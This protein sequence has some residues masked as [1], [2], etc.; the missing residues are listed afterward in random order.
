MVRPTVSDLNPVELKYYPF[1]ISLDKCSGSCD[2]LSSKICVRKE[3]KD[4]NIKAFNLITNKNEPKAMTEHIS[5]DCKCK[6]N[7]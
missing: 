7:M 4:I 1:I 5:R 2:V 6:F 3:T